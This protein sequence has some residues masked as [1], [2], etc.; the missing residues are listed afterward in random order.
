MKK[1][2]VI[3]PYSYLPYFSGGQKTIANFL[4]YLG[5]ESDVTVIST[6]K[7]DLSAAR[8]Y[9]LKRWLVNPF[10]RYLDVR[11]YFKIGK[12]LRTAR[13][14]CIIW[15]HPYFFWL[16]RLIQKKYGLYT[17]VHSHN[18]EF[19][20]FRSTGKWWWR[21][22]R[23]Y[24]GKCLQSA[25]F[26]YF[27]SPADQAEGIQEWSLDPKK[28]DVLPLGIS[29]DQ[30]PTDRASCQQRIRQRHNIPDDTHILLFNGLLDY[31]PNRQALDDLLEHINPLLYE[32]TLFRYRLIICGK[33]LPLN[34]RELTE[35]QKQ[36]VIYAG[37]VEDIDS[38]F[39]AADVFLNPVLSGGGIKT[40]MVE[41]IGLGTT[42]VSTQTGATG[43][44]PEF[45]GKKLITVKDHDWK[46]FAAQVIEQV[47]EK[48]ITP[49]LYY[50]QYFWGNIV[51][52]ITRLLTD[53]SAG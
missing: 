29:A 52:K 14:D 9:Q 6:Q 45:C 24:E 40:K 43:M 4:E 5:N 8:G 19:Q 49:D 46:E 48:S 11:L 51:K 25:D 27:I 33:N 44:I 39:K 15:I 10:W 38:Y 20:R 50:K 18:I 35:Y 47:K 21:L 42:V 37:F 22:L 36:H 41:A 34:Y 2:L 13:F 53:Q 12:L 3:A 28:C 30:Y 32:Q 31:L 7:N 23:T 26:N 1:I 16:S 17:I